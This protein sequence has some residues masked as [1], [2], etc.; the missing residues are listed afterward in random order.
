[1]RTELGR[2]A[3]LSER[4]SDESPLEIQVRRV[5]WLIAL[6][7]VGGGLA[8]V[9]SAL[10]RGPPVRDSVTFA[11]GL[12][13]ANVPEGLL[14]TITLALA[15][16]R[17]ARPA[18]R[19]RQAPERGRD[20]R[21][22]DRDLHRQDRDADREPNARTARLDAG[23]ERRPAG[24]RSRSATRPAVRR[25]RPRSP[26]AATP[27]STPEDDRRAAPAIRPSSRCSRRPARLGATSARDPRE[28][29]RGR[30]YHFDPDLKRM[31]TVDE[32][33]TASRSTRRAPRRSCSSGRRCWTPTRRRSRSTGPAATRSL[34]ASSAYGARAPR[35][36]GRRPRPPRRARPASRGRRARAVPARA[37]RAARSSAAGGGRGGRALP[38]GR[39]PIIVVTGDHGLTATEIARRVGI[40]ADGRGR[41]GRGARRMQE[42]E[43]DRLLR[44]GEELVFARSSPRRSSGSPTRSARRATWS[45]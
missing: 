24:D 38:R 29:S 4:C 44:E 7:A 27:S 32:G 26:R 39:D 21:L 22:D 28:A 30:Q 17:G 1:M 20:A 11:I 16:G 14:P 2:I 3:A 40:D 19:P 31:S 33:R 23:R 15:V 25:L 6:V 18:P 45:R 42:A 13:V 8:F 9:P 43:L 12:L 10:G 41:H 5:A 35:A 34:R 37:G 36:R